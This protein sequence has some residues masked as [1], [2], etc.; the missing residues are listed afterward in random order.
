VY[1]GIPFT[2][3]TRLDKPKKLKSWGDAVQDPTALALFAKDKA[4]F[5]GISPLINDESV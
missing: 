5:D 3:H 1:K 4:S 2:L